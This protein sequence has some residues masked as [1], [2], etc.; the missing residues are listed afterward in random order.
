MKLEF[1]VTKP[2]EKNYSL[3]VKVNSQ[4]IFTAMLPTEIAE[5]AEKLHVR[6]VGH[7]RLRRFGYVESDTLAG[8]KSQVNKVVELIGSEK[9]VAREN[10]IRFQINTICSY[11]FTAGGR[12]SPT[13]GDR[14]RG[15]TDWKGGTVQV[16]SSHPD[17][18]GISFWAHPYE[19]VTLRREYDGEERVEYHSLKKHGFPSGDEL[20]NDPVQW[21]AFIPNQRPDNRMGREQELPL[22][23][24]TIRFF[25]DLYCSLFALNE[26]VKPFLNPE[27]ILELASSNVMLLG[28]GGNDDSGSHFNGKPD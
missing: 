7:N 4:G 15:G 24:A 19:K 18:F 26:K 8:L 22:T 3:P 20:C 25:V 6:G 27:G 23:D 28:S 9:E 11:A 5:I 2:F 12:F 13:A 21:L 16:D 17:T 1:R 14:D 10:V